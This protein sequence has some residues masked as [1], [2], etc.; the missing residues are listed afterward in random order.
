MPYTKIT[1]LKNR[2]INILKFIDSPAILPAVALIENLPNEAINGFH[3]A[4][5]TS[6]VISIVL[7]YLTT[8]E[9]KGFEK[10]WINSNLIAA[11]FGISDS[12]DEADESLDNV[13]AKCKANPEI[14]LLHSLNDFFEDAEV[15]CID[16]RV[17]S[18]EQLKMYSD[19]YIDF[20]E[21]NKNYFGDNPDNIIIKN[22]HKEPE[23]IKKSTK[24][25]ANPDEKFI[26]EKSGS[27]MISNLKPCFGILMLAENDNK[28]LACSAYHH[29]PEYTSNEIEKYTSYLYSEILKL[30][31]ELQLKGYKNQ[32]SCVITGSDMTS[33]PLALNLLMKIWNENQIK[34]ILDL[35]VYLMPSSIGSFTY[36]YANLENN[37][38]EIWA[39]SELFDNDKVLCKERGISFEGLDGN[40]SDF[41]SDSEQSDDSKSSSENALEEKSPQKVLNRKRQGFFE[42]RVDEQGGAIEISKKIRF[43]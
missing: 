27:L 41:S 7:T 36:C 2:F 29:M 4:Y 18:L 32:M 14:N 42:T 22:A 8:S 10:D 38:C 11:L 25:L 33:F 17:Q 21:T 37:C 34:S 35:D 13:I 16:F 23:G 15:G 43:G 6:K 12:E 28:D 31:E 5:L 20:Y 24:N 9:I 26:I 1:Y 3:D 30:T 40:D 19:L 39:G